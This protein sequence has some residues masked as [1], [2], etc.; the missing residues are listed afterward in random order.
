LRVLNKIDLCQISYLVKYRR[1]TKTK[2][3]QLQ[4]SVWC[5]TVNV[6]KSTSVWLLWA[7]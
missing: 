7:T 3:K 6:Y 4:F 1:H 2:H 5:F